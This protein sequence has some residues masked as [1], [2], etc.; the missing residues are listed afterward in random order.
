VLYYCGSAFTIKLPA[1]V[2]D[3]TGLHCIVHCT[4]PVLATG[5]GHNIIMLMIRRRRRRRRRVTVK[6]AKIMGS[7]ASH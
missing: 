5:H 2:I 6:V 4:H 1:I 3:H 7:M